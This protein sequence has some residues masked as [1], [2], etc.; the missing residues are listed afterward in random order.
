MRSNPVVSRAILSLIIAFVAFPA[1]AQISGLTARQSSQ[2]SLKFLAYYQGV[3]D[4]N[5]NFSVDASGTCTPGP[6][7]P[8]NVAFPCNGSS[9]IEAKGSGGAGML[10]LAWQAAE[11]FQLYAHVGTGDYS[12]KVP[13]TTVGNTISGDKLGLIF[14]AGLRASIVPD[15]IVNPAIALDLRITRSHYNFNHI[16]P[17]G[18]SG[19]QQWI[20]HASH[21][22]DLSGRRRDEPPLRSR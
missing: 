7:N 20:Q 3:S 2:S 1:A 11:R 18:N 15:T 17:G 16:T 10:K 5:L 4:Q 9:D 19:H 12:I 14:G 13:S 6:Q 22:D 8:H 21:F